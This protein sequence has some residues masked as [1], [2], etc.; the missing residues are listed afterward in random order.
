L[1][2]VDRTAQRPRSQ[3]GVGLA[4]AFVAANLRPAIAS[5]APLLTRIQDSTGLSG[6]EAGLLTTIPLVAFGACSLLAPVLGRRIGMEATVVGALALLVCGIALRSVPTLAALFVGTAVLGVA[7]ALG[8]VIVPALVKRDFPQRVGAATGLYSVAL[9][10]AAALAAGITIPIVDAIGGSWRDGLALWAVPAAVCFALWLRRLR[11]AHH[12]L[13]PA[14]VGAGFWRDPL[15]W[16]ITLFMGIQSLGYYSTL[17]WLPTDFEQH[18]LHAATA[19]WLISLAGFCQVPT[20]FAMPALAHSPLRQRIAVVVTVAMNAAALAGVLVRPAA[21]AAVWMVLLGL[22]QGAA[23]GLALNFILVR[24]ASVHGA[25][26]LSAMAQAGGYLLAS[27]GPATLGA[28]H[29]ATGGW[30]VPMLALVVVL[31]PELACG[32]AASRPLVLGDDLAAP[33]EIGGPP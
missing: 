20:A 17:A 12:D 16:Q 1:V 13:A 30:T 33:E 10:G 5:V 15:S 24:A 31:A 14:R 3:I 23:L 29:D 22:A 11:D 8:N 27:A 2:R 6:A 19:G 18:G 9:T 4:V 21:G 32:I 26:Q 28:L 7:I 25:A